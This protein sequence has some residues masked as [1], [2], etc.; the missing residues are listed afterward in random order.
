MEWSSW[1]IWG[2]LGSLKPCGIELEAHLERE[3]V[4]CMCYEHDVS[5]IYVEG[6]KRMFGKN[7]LKMLENEENVS[8]FFNLSTVKGKMNFISQF[9]KVTALSSLG[10]TE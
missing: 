6:N 9:L 7:F 2:V 4:L 8:P 1:C 10:W 5:H 3:I